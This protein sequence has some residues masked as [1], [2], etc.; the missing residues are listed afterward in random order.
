MAVAYFGCFRVP[1][2]LTTYNVHAFTTDTS[3]PERRVFVVAGVGPDYDE[4]DLTTAYTT[5]QMWDGGTEI[6]DDGDWALIQ[7][8][9]KG[10]DQIDQSQAR[11][12]SWDSDT[13][14]EKMIT[15]HSYIHEDQLKSFKMW[16]RMAKDK[17]NIE[18]F[19]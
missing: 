3:I 16:I 12:D 18:D 1:A 14:T 13:T 6:T 7:I 11:Y 2:G 19:E 8:A 9:I 4:T 15:I 5:Q 10:Q 17:L